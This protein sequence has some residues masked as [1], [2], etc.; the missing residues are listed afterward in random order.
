[1]WF[2]NNRKHHHDSR[3]KLRLYV[4]TVGCVHDWLRFFLTKNTPKHFT[5]AKA[6]PE[7]IIFHVATPRSGAYSPAYNVLSPPIFNSKFSLIGFHRLH[8]V[9]YDHCKRSSKLYWLND[10]QELESFYNILFPCDGRQGRPLDC[11][12]L[13]AGW[14][15]HLVY[16]HFMPGS[17]FY[18]SLAPSCVVTVIVKSRSEELFLWFRLNL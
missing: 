5:W 17:V 18:S 13:I 15:D 3:K 1:M 2:C 4:V 16:V 11:F 14:G 10:R 6:W 8:A 12:T 7:P 9:S